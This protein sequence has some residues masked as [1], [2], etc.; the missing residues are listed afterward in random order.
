MKDFLVKILLMLFTHTIYHFSGTYSPHKMAEIG[1]IASIIAVGQLTE[2]V[3]SAFKSYIETV[4]D[5]PEYCRHIRDHTE[6]LN[7][8]FAEIRSLDSTYPVNSA[9]LEKLQAIDGPIEGCKN[10]MERLKEL[11]PPVSL[12]DPTI[13]PTIK[14]HIHAGFDRLTWPLNATR[15]EKILGEIKRHESTIKIALLG[16]SLKES[17]AVKSQVDDVQNKLRFITKKTLCDWYED[18]IHTNPSSKHNDANELYEPNTGNWVFRTTEWNEWI[19]GRIKSIL[20]SGIPGAGKTILAAH[21]IETLSRMCEVEHERMEC[22]YYYCYYGNS[23]DESRPFLRWIVSQL[24]REIHEI[25][26]I[27]YKIYNKNAEPTRLQLL[28]ILDAS[29]EDFGRVYVVV[30]ALDESKDTDN[31]LALL[32]VLGTDS[33]FQ[34]IRLFALSREHLD[35]QSTMC[36]F[37]TP[38][39]MSNDFVKAD[40]ETYVAAKIQSDPKFACWPPQLRS[41]RDV[42]LGCVPIGYHKTVKNQAKIRES[43]RSLPKTLDETYER[44]FA[45]IHEADQDFVRHTLHLL[46]FHTSLWKSPIRLTAQV[47]IDSYIVINKERSGS[48]SEDY[49]YTIDTVKNLCGC[50]VSVKAGV[51]DNVT[52]DTKIISKEDRFPSV[53]FAHYTVREFLASDRIPTTYAFKLDETTCYRTFLHSLMSYAIEHDYSKEKNAWEDRGAPLNVRPSRASSLHEYSIITAVRA[54]HT[55][56]HLFEPT[57]VYRFLDPS[58]RHYSALRTSMF[59]LSPIHKDE[60]GLKKFNT[61]F[62]HVL[63]AS[64]ATSTKS[65]RDAAILFDLILSDC[66]ELAKV[67]VRNIVLK[68][69][70]REVL[71]GRVKSHYTGD[72]EFKCKLVELLAE[73]RKLDAGALCFF[74]DE[75]P[76][77]VSYKDILPRWMPGHSCGW[78]NSCKES[79]VLPR[80][81]EMGAEREPKDFRATPLQIAVYYRDL[82]GTKALLEAGADPN[83]TGY[84]LKIHPKTD[85]WFQKDC[86]KLPG[87]TPLYILTNKPAGTVSYGASKPPEECSSDTEGDGTK[88]D[89]TKGDSTFEAK[90]AKIKHLLEKNRASCYL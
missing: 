48:S 69:V 33:R 50:L 86:Y 56:E 30:D 35:I 36:R 16:Q 82:A 27:A 81:I 87:R 11:L 68:N 10:A 40:I 80:L 18:T 49:L 20:C 24:L 85:S 21:V 83:H 84:E 53:E 15:A 23:Q 38:L 28:E 19:N 26:P 5:C 71:S 51:P 17:R 88:G 41:D 75:A 66:F 60:Y 4:K 74:E 37:S 14:Q 13:N 73:F 72:W 34:K 59:Q 2:S 7:G 65:S 64:S 58:K 6:A 8:I 52:F 3:A 70:L 12:P 79:C 25:P 89:G 55:R 54:L 77:I 31:L 76:G 45:S 67:F 39:S 1:L 46:C 63:W 43:L 42:S 61:R 62:W 22:F 90:E 57:L 29:L 9:I 47:V 44:I 78:F 32:E